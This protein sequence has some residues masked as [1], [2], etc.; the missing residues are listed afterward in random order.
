MQTA[1]KAGGIRPRAATALAKQRPRCGLKAS[2]AGCS[3]RWST[4]PCSRRRWD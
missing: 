3:A 2:K 4:W 1:E